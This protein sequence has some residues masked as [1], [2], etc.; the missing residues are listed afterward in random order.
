R[1]ASGVRGIKLRS[2]D[3]LV[4]MV[5]ASPEA[6]LLTVCEKGYGKRTPFGPNAPPIDEPEV[7]DEVSDSEEPE[8]ADEGEDHGTSARYPTK[9][10]GTMGVRDIKT[11]ERNGPVVA[12]VSVTDSD[13]LMIMTARGKLQRIAASDVSVIGRNTQGVKI[14]S[15]DDGDS[16]AAVVRVEPDEVTPED[17]GDDP[18][19]DQDLTGKSPEVE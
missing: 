16:V 4:G 11:T 8:V 5:V 2:G 12:V 10:R 6:T 19:V 1:S 9:G 7:A 17:R 15:L 18:A 14:M 13:E 3:T